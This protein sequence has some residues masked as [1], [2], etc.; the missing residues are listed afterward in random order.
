MTVPSQSELQLVVSFLISTLTLHAGLESYQSQTHLPSQ[1]AQ[2]TCDTCLT[3]QAN[4]PVPEPSVKLDFEPDLPLL[5]PSLPPSPP[6]PQ[7]ISRKNSFFLCHLSGVAGQRAA[8]ECCPASQG[9][10]T[11]L[12]VATRAAVYRHGCSNAPQRAA[13]W[14]S[15]E[16]DERSGSGRRWNT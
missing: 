6:P 4:V 16:S 14:R 5:P 8:H 12:V 11:A 3:L 10:T 7:A 15:T 13:E 1:R 9:A 2:H